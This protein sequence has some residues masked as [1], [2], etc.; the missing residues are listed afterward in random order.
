M[1]YVRNSTSGVTI[2]IIAI[3][4]FVFGLEVALGATE[5][6]D[7]LIGMG[8]RYGPLIETGEYWRLLSAVFLH[9]SL[10][11]LLS[12][13][14]SLWIMGRV[15]ER[16]YGHAVFL[17]LYLLSGAAGNAV[18]HKFGPQAVSIGA[19][20]AIFGIM[21]A[22]LVLFATRRSDPQLRQASGFIIPMAAVQTAV[23]FIPG[24]G[25]G[26]V[27]TAGHLGGLAAG[28]IVA[29]VLAFAATADS[30]RASRAPRVHRR[31][32]T[33]YAQPPASLSSRRALRAYSSGD[34]IWRN[35]KY[36]RE[37]R[38]TLR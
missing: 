27:D 26:R 16:F 33:G 30:A 2:A 12:N 35:S 22:I 21:G 9:L 37:R 14:L 32:R 29:S 34:E 8:A 11:H 15:A 36:S 6:A 1:E 4:V 25:E 28:L 18:S 10:A 5:D 19:S 17:A 7:T 20:G 31:T 3:C 38:S 13:M 24:F 23:N